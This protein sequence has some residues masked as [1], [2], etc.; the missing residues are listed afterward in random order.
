[1]ALFGGVALTTPASADGVSLDSVTP[2]VVGANAATT[3]RIE[4]S[5]FT[6]DDAVTIRNCPASNPSA[7]Y[8][9]PFPAPGPGQDPGSVTFVDS[10]TLLMTTPTVIPAGECDIYIGDTGLID[11]LSFTPAPERLTVEIVNT[12]EHADE[13]VWVTVGYNCPLGITSPPWPP[14]TQGCNTDGT[15]NPDYAWPA[16]AG[17]SPRRFWYEVYAGQQP[18]PAFTGI[19]LTDLPTVPGRAHTY[20]LSV[21]N[22]NS[23]VVYVAY[24][25]AVNTGSAAA[26]RA[27]SYLT[28]T[29]RFDVFE[30]TFHGSG[31]SAGDAGSGMWTNQVYANV[32]GVSGIGILMQMEGLDN[33]Q[34]A[35]DRA[36]VGSGRGL[37][38]ADGLTL[39][40]IYRA[41]S[42]AGIDVTDPKVV[43]T[44]DGAEPNASNFLR[45]VSP[46]TNEGV[47]YPDLGAGASSY[48][49][50]LTDQKATM[51]LVG[52]Y[53]GAGAGQGTWFCY[54]TDVF[55]AS[56][57]TTM[58]GSYGFS[59]RSAAIDAAASDCT[60][61]TTGGVITTATTP[62]SGTP[63]PVDSQAIYMQ[64]NRF[65]VDG[66][67]AAGNDL[68]NAVFR[69]FIVSFSY[70]YW[71]SLAGAAGWTTATWGT[72]SPRAF[73]RAWPSLPDSTTY[74][75]W[76]SY[77]GVIWGL[78][79]PYGMPYSD[80]FDNA[81]KG[82]PLVSGSSI[83]TLRVTLR[84]DG[85]WDGERT[86]L[87]STQRITAPK[88]TTFASQPLTAIGF[89]EDVTYRVRPRLPT[90]RKRAVDG[91]W[92]VRST[93]VIKGTP[94]RIAARTTYR[95]SAISDTERVSVAKI[96]LHVPRP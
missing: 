31:T 85:P 96:R 42:Q 2:S 57:P 89:E 50:W 67:P 37:A 56:K 8:P 53:S 40:D 74:P 14:G 81:G 95:I 44:T 82:N 60:G 38:G 54:R 10:S 68:Y 84:A 30:L 18:L 34:E 49:Q 36:R 59:S 79:N 72:G 47:G 83:T 6:P 43:V 90:S 64:N 29:T 71:G 52:L 3:V 25:Q 26:G 86:L 80:T 88:G 41:M 63:G 58:R 19:R 13:E 33:S 9:V 1:M 48:L 76:N 35:V 15:V 12:S 61:G 46:S 62:T 4:G 75:R 22:I 77:A 20:A 69:D 65:V 17:Q 93:G 66:K 21:A 78:G 92:F 70:G 32:T 87:P 7:V 73:D 11:A 28:S 27:P 24:D 94:T 91:F 16:E 45:F 39:S 23:G 5:G 55:D 51:I